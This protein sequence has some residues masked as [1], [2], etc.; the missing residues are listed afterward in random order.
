[1]NQL[2]QCQSLEDL[3]DFITSL[4]DSQSELETKLQDTLS[5]HLSDVPDLIQ[6]YNIVRSS[7]LTLSSLSSHTLPS[8]LSQ[9]KETLATIPRELSS[10]ISS[11]Q[12]DLP[13][14]FS[15]Y[16]SLHPLL[17]TPPLL[18]SGIQN[19]DYKLV[20]D[21]LS[22]IRQIKDRL[23]DHVTPEGLKLFMVLY[24]SCLIQAKDLSLQLEQSVK[25]PNQFDHNV[26][27]IA[28]SI[29]TLK[30]VTSFTDQPVNNEQIFKWV[31]DAFH[32]KTVT[33]MKNL[34][35]KKASL[36]QYLNFMDDISKN[37]KF[38]L[39]LCTS[40][41]V[42][43]HPSLPSQSV[44]ID[45]DSDEVVDSRLLADFFAAEAFVL[46]N[47]S[48]IFARKVKPLSKC[49][50]VLKELDTLSKFLTKFGASLDIM[51]NNFATGLIVSQSD[52]I[53]VKRV[54][55]NYASKGDI[56]SK[57]PDELIKMQ[58]F[59]NVFTCVYEFVHIFEELSF[60]TFERVFLNEISKHLNNFQ[61]SLSE[62]E[63]KNLFDSIFVPF[64]EL[65]LS[66][67]YSKPES[68]RTIKLHF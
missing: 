18:K 52:N 12:N 50:T 23:I 30:I 22:E 7:S 42:V 16:S 6:S 48:L 51:L 55:F 58:N 24:D 1:M 21:I 9:F 61:L 14:H 3:K 5:I 54:E 4:E 10:I 53:F 2:E 67:F 43:N 35:L 56:F 65:F 40:V 45:L 64:V 27:A 31:L 38:V 13:D 32:E 59:K 28:N 19:K 37:H 33:L 41:F 46:L 66:D 26:E 68:S 11:L 15:L 8:H 49:V 36:S 63:D 20:V 44:L 17:N 25:N 62:D 60:S 47:T 34:D 39:S 29:M 57:F